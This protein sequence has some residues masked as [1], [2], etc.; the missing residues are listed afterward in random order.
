MNRVL[1]GGRDEDR[2]KI[3]FPSCISLFDF[4]TQLKN[5]LIENKRIER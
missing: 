2:T 3:D 5:N 4:S 1:T